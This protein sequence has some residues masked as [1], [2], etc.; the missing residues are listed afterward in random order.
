MTIV[1]VHHRAF[2]TVCPSLSC[3]QNWAQQYRCVQSFLSRQ[4]ETFHML[5]MLPHSVQDGVGLLCHKVTLMAHSHHVVNS[6]PMSF[7]L[8]AAFRV[9]ATQ[10]VLV[11]G[12]FSSQMQDFAFL[13]IAFHMLICPVLQFLKVPLNR[14]TSIWCINSSY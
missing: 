12:F 14:S 1:T 13:F 3:S 5:D 4:E 7:S 6:K 2:A 11:P 10:R 9:V 8:L